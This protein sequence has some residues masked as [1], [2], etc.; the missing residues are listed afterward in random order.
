MCD[1]ILK[2][3]LLY[4]N[5]FSFHVKTS[6]YC[7]DSSFFL[8]IVNLHYFTCADDVKYP[9]RMECLRIRNARRLALYYYYLYVFNTKS[10]GI[11]HGFEDYVR[12]RRVLEINY[13]LSKDAHK[14]I[15]NPHPIFILQHLIPTRFF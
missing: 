10:K 7:V 9:I 1:L 12:D 14:L 3:I 11:L 5:G 2:Q 8:S 13:E 15:S 4:R 6:E